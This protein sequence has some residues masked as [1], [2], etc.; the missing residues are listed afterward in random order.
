MKDLEAEWKQ[1]GYIET[2]VV[3][4]KAGVKLSAGGKGRRGFGYGWGG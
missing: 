4:V 2:T 3:V 1:C